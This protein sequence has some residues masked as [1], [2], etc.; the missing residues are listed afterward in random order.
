MRHGSF[1][2]KGV[3][4]APRRHGPETA[5]ET[6]PKLFLATSPKKRKKVLDSVT[7]HSLYYPL[8]EETES[9]TGCAVVACREFAAEV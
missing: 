7:E 1:R 8:T 5:P 2:V 6:P 3:V 4:P 9:C